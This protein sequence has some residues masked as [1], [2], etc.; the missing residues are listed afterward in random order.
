MLEPKYEMA[1]FLFAIFCAYWAQT[2][3]RSAFLWFC[4]GLFIAPLAG[5]ALLYLNHTDNRKKNPE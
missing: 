1:F 2:S 5:I 4:L 3:K